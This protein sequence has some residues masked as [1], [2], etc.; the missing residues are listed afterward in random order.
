MVTLETEQ[1][2]KACIAIT[3]YYFFKITSAG[4]NPAGLLRIQ[5]YK[6]LQLLALIAAANPLASRQLLKIKVI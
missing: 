3:S 5:S 4:I 2:S 1:T 6:L